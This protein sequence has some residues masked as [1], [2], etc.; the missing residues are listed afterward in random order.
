[1]LSDI[2]I[3]RARRHERGLLEDLQRRASLMWD[4]YREALLAHPD[5]I[6]LPDA[7]IA[8]GRVLVAERHATVLGFC[9]VLP[10]ADGIAELD[11]LFVAPDL[12]RQGIGRR[13][14]QAAERLARAEGAVVLAVI[15]APEARGFYEA[16]NFEQTHE[17]ATRFG[18]ALGMRK[19]LSD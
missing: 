18:T 5:A 4:A 2:I 17:Q 8:A 6:E 11:G 19:Q 10:G 9:V 3:R 15:A 13:L 7:Q 16:C 14:V 12:A 1:M